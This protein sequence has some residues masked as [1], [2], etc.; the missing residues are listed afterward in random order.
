MGSPRT[1]KP[2]RSRQAMFDLLSFNWK[3]PLPNSFTEF[4]GLERVQNA[5]P[6]HTPRNLQIPFFLLGYDAHRPSTKKGI[7]IHHGIP[8][9]FSFLLREKQLLNKQKR[10]R[11]VAYPFGFHGPRSGRAPRTPSRAQLTR[12]QGL[13]AE[14]TCGIF[15]SWLVVGKHVLH[16]FAEVA[17]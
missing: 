6:N 17:V 14:R 10:R 15:L 5:K 1:S 7:G 16:I 4:T 9:F 12:W 11:G 2:N 13:G 3:L 8:S